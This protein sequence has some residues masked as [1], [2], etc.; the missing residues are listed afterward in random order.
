LLIRVLL[1]ILMIYAIWQ[2]VK[3]FFFAKKSGNSRK[4]DDQHFTPKNDAGKQSDDAGEYVDY[5]EIK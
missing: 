4:E 3:V 5:E 1:K 2:V